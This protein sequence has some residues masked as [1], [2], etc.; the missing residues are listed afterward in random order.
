MFVIG[1]FAF[2]TWDFRDDTCYI[3]LP[4]ALDSVFGRA[5]GSEPRSRDGDHAD[6]CGWAAS[7]FPERDDTHAPQHTPG[8]TEIATEVAPHI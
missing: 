3:G 6:A 1:F 8:A 5:R 2:G 4:Q 7:L